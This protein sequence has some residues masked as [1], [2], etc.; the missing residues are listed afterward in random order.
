LKAT[1]TLLALV[2]LVGISC[3]SNETPDPQGGGPSPP[4]VEPTSASP[5]PTPAIVGMW[6]RV[7]M[8]EE[9]V[10]ALDEAGLGALAPAML[11]GN[12][13]VPGS[14]KQLAKREDI[15]EGARP[16]LHSHFFAAD[17]DFGSLDWNFEQV[18]DGPWE[19]VSDDTIHIGDDAFGVDFRYLITDGGQTLTLEPLLDQTAK[20]EALAHPLEF[21]VAGWGVAVAFPGYTWTRAE[22]GNWC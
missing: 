1:V 19:Q 4:G 10:D 17:G 7:T 13:L 18:D 11:A 22:C 6:E 14:A 12:G 2:A 20:R 15:C 3:G 5:S 16:R 21:S 9:M 8:C